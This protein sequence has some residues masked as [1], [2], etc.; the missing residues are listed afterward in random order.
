MTAEDFVM[1]SVMM[2]GVVISVMMTGVMIADKVISVNV[3]AVKV[4]SVMP[5]W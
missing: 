5:W 2:T 4:I 1:I 3:T